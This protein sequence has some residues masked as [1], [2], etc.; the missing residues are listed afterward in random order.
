[1]VSINPWL[2][3][4]YVMLDEQEVNVFSSAVSQQS[5]LRK[6]DFTNPSTAQK[7]LPLKH[8]LNNIEADEQHLQ[9]SLDLED[10]SNLNFYLL[11]D[12]D[13]YA[14]LVVGSGQPLA[15]YITDESILNVPGNL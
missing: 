8:V 12:A 2:K 10:L 13:R 4:N 3:P 7:S 6:L 1:M 14:V 9:N 11:V 5:L 15:V